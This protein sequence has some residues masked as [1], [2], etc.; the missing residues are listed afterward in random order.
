VAG[1]TH[2]GPLGYGGGAGG[3][4]GAQA[5]AGGVEPGLDRADC[6]GARV[7]AQEAQRRVL[8]KQLLSC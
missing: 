6:A 4:A 5:V 1:L 3:Q 7:E 8:A 2:D